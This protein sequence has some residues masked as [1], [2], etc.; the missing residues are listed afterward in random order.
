V[1]PWEFR[2]REIFDL[3]NPVQ[4]RAKALQR[5]AATFVMPHCNV[6]GNFAKS[7][8]PIGQQT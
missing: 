4:T 1:R 5:R 7:F 2:V 3:S 8:Q 6:I